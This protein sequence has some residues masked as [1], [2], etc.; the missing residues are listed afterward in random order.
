VKLSGPL[1]EK[2]GIFERV[3][4]SE[5]SPK[6]WQTI[7]RLC[8]HAKSKAKRYTNMTLSEWLCWLAVQTMI[9]NEEEQK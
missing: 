7:A 2:K 1:M 3:G 9:R 8:R 6:S 5:D 4:M